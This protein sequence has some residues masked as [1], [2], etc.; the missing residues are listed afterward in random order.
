MSIPE[1]RLHHLNKSC[2]FLTSASASLS[3][4]PENHELLESVNQLPNSLYTF[5]HDIKHL[6]DYF[7]RVDDEIKC[8]NHNSSEPQ[9]LKMSCVQKIITNIKA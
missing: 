2:N 5:G 9:L 1:S 3:E 4:L 8:Q 6:N 7:L